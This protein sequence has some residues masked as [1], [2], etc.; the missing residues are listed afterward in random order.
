MNPRAHDPCPS[1]LFARRSLALAGLLLFLVPLAACKDGESPSGPSLPSAVEISLSSSN[2]PE[3]FSVVVDL[4]RV[5]AID[6]N[7]NPHSL[8]DAGLIELL[9]LEDAPTGILQAPLANG[10]YQSLELGFD[11]PDSTVTVIAGG[12]PVPLLFSP[13]D[14]SV[15]VEFSVTEGATARV[16]LDIDLDGLIQA[17]D[18]TW[19]LEPR[20]GV[21]GT[22]R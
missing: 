17:A 22:V 12:P 11:L 2:A 1:P 18:G 15:P 16:R 7:G 20:F 13:A 8:G 10:S 14:V 4:A 5:Q 6:A 9:A 19:I 21:V 3:L